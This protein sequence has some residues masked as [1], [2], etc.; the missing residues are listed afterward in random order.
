MLTS[1]LFLLIT[2]FINDNISILAIFRIFSNI[3]QWEFDIIIFSA[4]TLASQISKIRLS[5]LYFI[6]KLLFLA[7][8]HKLYDDRYLPQNRCLLLLSILSYF[9][10]S[11]FQFFYPFYFLYPSYFFYLFYPFDTSHIVL[12]YS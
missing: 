10:N 2:A 3:Y 12:S 7:N 5:N 11:L 9:S 8:I 4:I 1:Y 6:I